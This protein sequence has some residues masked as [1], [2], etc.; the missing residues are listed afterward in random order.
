MPDLILTEEEQMLQTTVRDFVDR[1]IAP[2]A[3]ES[4][5]RGEFQWDNWRGLAD[6]GLTGLGIDTK[7]GGSGPAGYRQVS[8]AAGEPQVKR[9]ERLR[10]ERD[11]GM[12]QAALKRMEQVAQT[13]EN[14]VPAILECVE[15]YC[16]LGEICQVFRGVFGEQEGAFTF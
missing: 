1:E 3:K 16:T 9:L 13:D 7:Y 5:E 4:D 8:I 14:T 12:V 6:L 11:N 10:R 15:S 2:K